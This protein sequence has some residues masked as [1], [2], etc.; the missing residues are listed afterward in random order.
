MSLQGPKH[1]FFLVFAP[2]VPN[3]QEARARH[4]PA[5]MERVQ[6]L[7][8]SGLLSE[9]SDVPT[10]PSPNTILTTVLEQGLG[11]GFFPQTCEGPTRTRRARSV[12]GSSS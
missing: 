12:V 2:D 3:A 8:Q 11:A 4:L 1:N 9:C 6:R 5:H 10:A 7:A